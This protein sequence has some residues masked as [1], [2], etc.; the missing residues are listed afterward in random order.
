MSFFKP[1]E[2]EIAIETQEDLPKFHF[3]VNGFL[4]FDDQSLGGCGIYEVIPTIMTGA[5]THRETFGSNAVDTKAKGYTPSRAM[6]VVGDRRRDA[7]MQWVSFVNGLLPDD[8]AESQTHVQIILKKTHPDEWWDAYGYAI[9]NLHGH[10]GDPAPSLGRHGRAYRK[11]YEEMLDD[12]GKAGTSG[13]GMWNGASYDVLGYIVV[14]YTPSSEG[15][16]L[17]GRDD[18]YYVRDTHDEC[19]LFNVDGMAERIGKS[20]ASRRERQTARD[21]HNTADALFP[22]D[23][24]RIAQVLQ[25]RMR[26]IE[27]KM[28]AY[29]QRVGNDALAFTIRRTHM[30]D[31]SMLM[32]FWNDPLT[33][34]RYKVWNMHTDM[35]DV[36]TGMRNEEAAASGDISLLSNH[37]ATDDEM[38]SFLSMF[39][40]R[41]ANDADDS[42]E[43]TESEGIDM[44]EDV[45]DAWGEISPELASGKRVTPSDEDRF[46]ERY[47]RLAVSNVTASLT[48]SDSGKPVDGSEQ[49]DRNF[50]N[51]NRLAGNV[52]YAQTSRTDNVQTAMRQLDRE[53]RRR[54]SEQDDDKMRELGVSDRE[55]PRAPD[56]AQLDSMRRDARRHADKKAA[57]IPEIPTSIGDTGKK[58]AKR[59]DNADTNPFAKAAERRDAF[60]RQQ[61]KRRDAQ[62]RNKPAAAP[63]DG[64]GGAMTGDGRDAIP[65]IQVELQPDAGRRD[66]SGKK[67]RRR[68]SV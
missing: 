29:S 20:V 5:V 51:D 40:G 9:D 34:Y 17:D 66:G 43:S 62:A 15:W 31:N 10:I 39:D 52:T 68:I 8:E 19:S 56:R 55:M 44:P 47:R 2:K 7:V 46:I 18:D 37:E 41:E 26:K 64:M 35:S 61:A 6:E 30:V 42:N 67:R 27:R 1:K 60:D 33:S 11:S 13:N 36:I 48:P 24:E 4:M 32:S 28:S 38:S 45:S 63:A 58:A 49:H 25:T 50:G 53:R 23:E 22:I 14:S 3:D 59:P 21:E 65:E 54:L 57:E 12:L 16:W